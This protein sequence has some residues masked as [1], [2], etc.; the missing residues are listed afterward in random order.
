MSGISTHV[1]D[2]AKGQ[3]AAG[4]RVRLSLRGADIG[5][6]VT[7]EDGRIPALLSQ[8]ATLEQGCYQI[9]FETGAYFPRGFFPEVIIAFEVGDETA[10]YHVPLLI[11]PFGYTT[12]RGS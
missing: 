1:L 8:D 12:Y 10:H 9:L 7:G 11:S 6:G 4:I 3:P 5:S 2:T